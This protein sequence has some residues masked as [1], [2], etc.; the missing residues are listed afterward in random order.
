MH[1]GFALEPANRVGEGLAIGA[2]SAAQGLVVV[3]DCA[4]TERKHGGVAEAF[5]HYPR[6][7]DHGLLLQ[8]P[9]RVLAYDDRQLAARISEDL[10]AVNT[11]KSL[12]W[13]R[14]AGTNSAKK[15]L[16]FGDAVRVPSHKASP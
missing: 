8:F 5:T 11:M 1:F 13:E 15:C 12:N 10:A 14:T 4:E 6:M 16:L 9:R 3:K 7:L 2:N